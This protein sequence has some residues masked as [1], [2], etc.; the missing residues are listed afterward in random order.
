MDEQSHPVHGLTLNVSELNGKP[1][2]FI[3]NIFPDSVGE[4]ESAEASGARITLKQIDGSTVDLTVA[5]SVEEI[6]ALMGRCK[7]LDAETETP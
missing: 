6:R 5:Q 4:L 3:L 7:A 2:I 1:T